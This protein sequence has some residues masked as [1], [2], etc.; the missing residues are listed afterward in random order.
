MIQDRWYEKVLLGLQR[1]D[2]SITKA[3]KAGEFITVWLLNV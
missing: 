2:S 1:K 3:M